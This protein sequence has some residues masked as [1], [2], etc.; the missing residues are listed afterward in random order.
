MIQDL[1]EKIRALPPESQREVEDF[2]DFLMQKQPG[3]PVRKP[4]FEW[5]GALEHLRSQYTSV[6]LQHA[7]SD[8]RAGQNE[9]TG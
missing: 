6:E 1:G 9:D 5:A 3:R 4:S 8:W 7:I 2:V